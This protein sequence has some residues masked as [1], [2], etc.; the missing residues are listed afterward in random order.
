[1]APAV[2]RTQQRLPGLLGI[3]R[4]R[5]DLD[6]I[7]DVMTQQ[8]RARVLVEERLDLRPP[9]IDRGSRVAPAAGS[10]ARRNRSPALVVATR[11]LPS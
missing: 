5:D 4:I 7:G 1:M 3:E 10:G 11:V 9:P 2:D 6:G 8:V